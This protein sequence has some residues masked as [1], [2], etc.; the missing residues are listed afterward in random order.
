MAAALKDSVDAAVVEELARRF[1]AIDDRFDALAFTARTVPQ[2]AE[3]ELKARIELIAREVW[4]ALGDRD[5]AASLACLVES[6]GPNRRSRGGRRGRW[7]R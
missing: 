4:R 1:T 6:R 7:R 3:L 2:L 5:P